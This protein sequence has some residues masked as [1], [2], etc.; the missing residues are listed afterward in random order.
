MNEH[1]TVTRLYTYTIGKAPMQNQ[2]FDNCR[3][4]YKTQKK[5]PFALQ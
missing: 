2:C 4:H 1:N 5:R 3:R